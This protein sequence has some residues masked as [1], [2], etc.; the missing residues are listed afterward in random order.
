MKKIYILTPCYND[1]ESLSVLL[2]NIDVEIPNH[3]GIEINIAVINDCSTVPNISVESYQKAQYNNINQIIQL[4]LNRNVGHQRAICIGLAYLH[5]LSEDFD[6]IVVMDSDGEDDYLDV[7]QLVDV[8]T[9]DKIIFAKRGKRSEPFIFRIFYRLYIHFFKFFTGQIIRGGNFSLIPRNL[10][11]SVVHL[12]GIWNHYH[13]GIIKSKIPVSYVLCDRAKR[14]K[15][16]SKMNFYSLVIHGLSS[17][18]VFNEILFVKLT[19]C[20]FVLFFICVLAIISIIIMKFALRYLI[21]PWIVYTVGIA[22][23]LCANIMVILVCFTFLFLGNRNMDSFMLVKGYI[24]F[25]ENVK[26]IKPTNIT[27]R[28]KE[29]CMKA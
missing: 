9:D 22:F 10:L 18:S 6:C 26:V 11:S 20:S 27:G 7:F 15:G 25:I 17:A 16:K 29:K 5:S 4:D 1:F 12:S 13:A 23:M 3:A 19:I 24:M 14:Y 28:L 21:E 2:S 8:M